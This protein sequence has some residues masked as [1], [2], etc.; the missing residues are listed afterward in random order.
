MGSL[1]LRKDAVKKSKKRENNPAE[2]LTDKGNWPHASD[3]V[4]EA[5]SQHLAL[6]AKRWAC[7]KGGKKKKKKKKDKWRHATQKS[8]VKTQRSAHRCRFLNSWHEM[9]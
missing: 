3:G 5:R 7:K 1:R 9:E 6:V 4:R 8:L 2:T